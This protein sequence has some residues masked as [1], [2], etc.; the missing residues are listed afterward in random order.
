L[1]E[2]FA[3]ERNG[4]GKEFSRGSILAAQMT[5]S[6][7]LSLTLSYDANEANLTVQIRIQNQRTIVYYSTF[8]EQ[9]LDFI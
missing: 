3:D 6:L 8:R 5:L 1:T 9:L 4:D 2:E 7:I